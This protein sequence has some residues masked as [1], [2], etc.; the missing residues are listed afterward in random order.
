MFLLSNT[1]KYSR[2]PPRSKRK[3]L[4]HV[5]YNVP[6]PLYLI[7]A[8]GPAKKNMAGNYMSPCLSLFFLKT[9]LTSTCLEFL[10]TLNG[11][12]H[13]C[14]CDLVQPP[15]FT[16]L[17]DGPTSSSSKAEGKKRVVEEEDETTATEDDGLQTEKGS[18]KRKTQNR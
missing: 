2:D 9:F 13:V 7:A 4:E 18:K 14:T 16:L 11:L 10:E 15:T 12:T 5:P 3:F 17:H 8:K 1:N 6:R